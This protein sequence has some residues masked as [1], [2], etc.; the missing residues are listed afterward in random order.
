MSHPCWTPRREE[1]VL[2]GV[3][4]GF[5]LSG[6]RYT[7]PRAF[8][9]YGAVPQSYST[10]CCVSITHKL[11]HTY[12]RSCSQTYTNSVY[13]CKLSFLLFCIVSLLKANAA[14]S[15]VLLTE[16]DTIH[17]EMYDCRYLHCSLYHKGHF[18]SR[19]PR[20]R[21]AERG[22]RG[23]QHFLFSPGEM[24]LSLHPLCLATIMRL[25][26]IPQEMINLG[27]VHLVNNPP[28]ISRSKGRP[29][30]DRAERECLQGVSFDLC[31]E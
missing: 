3:A 19:Q 12:T 27:N 6:G 14:I 18:T 26:Y 29:G 8:D 21:S 9:L 13:S 7:V 25:K 17:D 10:L 31:E 24:K 5:L 30:K 11:I 1:T 22:L 23:G 15:S 20:W 4:L 28:F 2:P 16:N